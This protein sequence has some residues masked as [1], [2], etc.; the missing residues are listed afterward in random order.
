MTFNRLNRRIHFWGSIICVVPTIIVIVT[1]L[2]LLLR[3]EF[4]WIQPPTNNGKGTY[5]TLEFSRIIDICKHVEELQINDWKDISRFDVRPQD[6]IIKI[7]ANNNYEAQID[8]QTGE[9]L[10]VAKRRSGVIEKIHD[11]SFFHKYLSLGL[12]FPSALILLVISLTGI[13]IFFRT[14]SIRR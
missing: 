11:G 6:G 13:F 7:I 5:P 1:G 2:F 4:D 14:L 8:F 12:F 10:Q 9:V 3:K